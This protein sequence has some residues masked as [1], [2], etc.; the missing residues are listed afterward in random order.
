MC[1]VCLWMIVC[2]N[3]VRM[4]IF[5][6]KWKDICIYVNITVHHTTHT[7]ETQYN[8]FFKSRSLSLPL[9]RSLIQLCFA[10]TRWNRVYSFYSHFM[11]PYTFINRHIYTHI[12]IE[13]RW[14]RVTTLSREYYGLIYCSRHWNEIQ[15]YLTITT[16]ICRVLLYRFVCWHSSVAY[17]A[18]CFLAH[19]Y[20]QMHTHI[21][22]QLHTS[23]AT[24]PTS[25]SSELIY[26][27]CAV[28]FLACSLFAFLFIYLFSF[29]VRLPLEKFKKIF[30]VRNSQ[31]TYK[32][33]R[34]KAHTKC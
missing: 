24:T 33:Q 10:D 23:A 18:A 8:L 19:K 29:T 6:V 4:W 15:N 20:M 17:E 7:K 30:T 9:I 34:E 14:W 32:I 5:V 21:H 13:L 26:S 16:H 2:V 11:L 27:L 1:S 22:K 28:V 31:L 25:S 3:G 12:H